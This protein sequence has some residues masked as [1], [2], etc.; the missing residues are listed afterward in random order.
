M[1]KVIVVSLFVL[2]SGYGSVA[3]GGDMEPVLRC[4][5]CT[6][7]ND[8]VV[9]LQEE[10]NPDVLEEGVCGP[11]CSSIGSSFDD[12]D[13][14]EGSCFEALACTTDQ[15]QAPAAGPLWLTAAALGMALFGGLA[16]RRSR[17]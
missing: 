9:C 13:R 14:V 1:D 2:L 16:V 17:S 4:V 7:E 6:C 3:A 5:V 8:E 12:I 15:R 10:G 11:A